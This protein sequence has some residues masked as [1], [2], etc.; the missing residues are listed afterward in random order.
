MTRDIPE[1]RPV[2]LEG[3]PA[4]EICSWSRANGVDLIIAAAR[5]G[6]VE[7]A[8]LG[9]FAS[10]IAYHASCSVLLVHP[11]SESVGSARVPA[12]ATASEGR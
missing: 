6:I 12:G 10:H 11:P 1:A 9:G 5:R 8:M 2:L 3:S 7:R 4:H